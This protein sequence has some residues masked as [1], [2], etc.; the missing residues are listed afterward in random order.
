VMI[1]GHHMWFGSPAGDEV[2]AYALP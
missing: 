2:I 1:S